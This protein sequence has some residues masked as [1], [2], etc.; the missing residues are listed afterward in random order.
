VLK[1]R[2]G[3]LKLYSRA[4]YVAP[5]DSWHQPVELPDGRVLWKN[6]QYRSGK[7]MDSPE[8]QTCDK[9][10]TSSGRESASGDVKEFGAVGGCDLP[11]LIFTHGGDEQQQEEETK[12]ETEGIET[13]EGECKIHMLNNDCLMHI[14]SFLT[15]RERIRIERGMLFHIFCHMCV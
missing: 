11:S 1:L 9:A 12:S 7:E 8:T 10:V 2:H 6:H 5:A 13:E 15:K 14:F 3:E 4:L